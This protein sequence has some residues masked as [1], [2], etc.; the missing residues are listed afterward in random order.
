[1]RS[2]LSYS[3]AAAEWLL[4]VVP[5]GRGTWIVGAPL[6]RLL[7][8]GC[9]RARLSLLSEETMVPV[10]FDLGDPVQFAMVRNGH[11]DLGTA[12]VICA[13]LAPGDTYID[14]GANWGYFA[15]I[16]SRV[17]GI[18]G[19]V[20]AIEPNL[21]AFRH[22]QDTV[23]RNGLVNVLSVNVAA[24]EEVGRRVSLR[25]PFYR[26]TT[27]S[28]VCE[29]DT[30]A[31]ASIVTNTVDYLRNKVGGGPVRLLKVDV[32]GAELP[33][34]KGARELLSDLRPWV[35]LEVSSH[36]VRFGHSPQEV[37]DFMRTFGYVRA[38]L[39]S[40]E[41]GDPGVAEVV[42]DPIEG[43]ILFQPPTQQL[44]LPLHASSSQ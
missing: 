27:S 43:Q 16:A 35:I 33:V 18:S 23:H 26:Q 39:I 8:Q 15:C 12:T 34:L 22:F 6:A 30:D 17:V 37:Y 28:F 38:Y 3:C 29:T 42:G 31:P 9:R 4:R 36:A 44:P 32:E 21:D 10:E 5:S 40:D 25:R 14:V 41:P 2:V 7:P 20:L 19:L 11:F 24:F 1:M 13:L